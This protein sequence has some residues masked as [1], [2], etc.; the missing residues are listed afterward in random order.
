MHQY[1]SND[2]TIIFLGYRS[3]KTYEQLR[4]KI[5]KLHGKLE[6]HILPQMQRGAIEIICKCK[7]FRKSITQ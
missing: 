4:E 5:S 2:D 6:G 7:D 3:I 1:H